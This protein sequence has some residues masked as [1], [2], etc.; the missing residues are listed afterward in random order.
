VLQNLDKIDRAHEEI[1]GLNVERW[2]K[3]LRARL[4][5]RSGQTA[6]GKAIVDE[7]IADEASHPDPTVQFIPHL[8][9]VELAWLTNDATLATRHALRIAEIANGNS[10]PYVAVYAEACQGVALSLADNHAAAI[11]RLDRALDLARQVYAGLNFEP[12][13]LAYLAEV[14]MRAGQSDKAISRAREAIQ[15]SV[16]RGARL[17]ECRAVLALGHASERVG[18]ANAHVHVARGHALIEET[19]AAA[20]RA[21]IRSGERGIRELS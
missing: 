9:C 6:A 16:S 19:G 11:P 3:G 8:A 14:H 10:T 2:V 12:E 7:L 17:T 5:I 4:L 1:L 20:Y 18:A 21:L 15:V 13:I